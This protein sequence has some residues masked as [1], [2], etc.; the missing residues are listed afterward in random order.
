MARAL[1]REFVAPFLEVFKATLD[2]ALCDVICWE[3]PMPMTGKLELV[4]FKVLTK[5]NCSTI[6]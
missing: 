1:A 2:G 6:L 5:T 3:L 4:G